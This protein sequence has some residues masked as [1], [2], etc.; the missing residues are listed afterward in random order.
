M[1]MA[2]P[3]QDEPSFDG[4]PRT[5]LT[6]PA[7]IDVLWIGIAIAFVSASGPLITATVAPALAI[8]FWRCF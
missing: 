4:S 8:A 1:N 3:T 2:L 7:R 6:R 5:S